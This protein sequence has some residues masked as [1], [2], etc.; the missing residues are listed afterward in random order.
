MQPGSALQWDHMYL[1]PL[2]QYPLIVFF[3]R[4]S[5]VYTSFSFIAILKGQADTMFHGEEMP[6][7]LNKT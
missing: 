4:T 1:A 2:L 7:G 5:T 6:T 3:I